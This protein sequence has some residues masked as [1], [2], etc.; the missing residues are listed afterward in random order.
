[1]W[2]RVPS[3]LRAPVLAAA[4]EARAHAALSPARAEVAKAALHRAGN[5]LEELADNEINDSAFGY[6]EAQLHFHCGNAYTHLGDTRAAWQ[7][8]Q[9]ALALYP[10]TDFLD[11]AL[12]RLDRTICLARDGDSAGALEYAAAT[13]VPLTDD[14]REGLIRMRGQEVLNAIPR[15]QKALPAVRQLRELLAPSD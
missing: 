8:Q 2:P 14:Q 15:Q 12:T 5:L 6:N 9:Q 4:L 7:A 3:T 13:L 11:R 1:M 10:E